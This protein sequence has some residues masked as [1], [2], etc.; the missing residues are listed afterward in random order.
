MAPDQKNK[1]IKL[2]EK[3]YYDLIQA[4]REREN[5][6]CQ[7]CH[8][9][10]PGKMLTGHHLKSKGSGGNDSLEN[11]AC[12]CSFCHIKIHTGEMKL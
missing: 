10:F 7:A 3:A 4:V 12:V 2:K 5:Y 11:L 9:I 6:T 8:N 1:R